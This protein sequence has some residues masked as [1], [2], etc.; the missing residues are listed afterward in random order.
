[1]RKITG[2][3]LAGL[4]V[5]CDIGSEPLQA[6]TEIGCEDQLS[7][8]ASSALGSRFG[9]EITMDGATVSVACDIPAD[10]V[11]AQAEVTG[12]ST[13]IVD[14]VPDGIVIHDLPDELGVR[15]LDEDGTVLGEAALTPA[16]DTLYPNGEECGPVC[17]QGDAVVQTV[18][19]A[20]PNPNT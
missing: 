11:G 16:Y 17:E 8:Q 20:N 4:L 15:F 10:A 3:A 5:G 13:L 7:I 18:V 6:C 12:S 19:A 1:M 9:A 2:I 14:C